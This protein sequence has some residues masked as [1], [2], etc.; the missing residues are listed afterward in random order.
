MK[1]RDSSDIGTVY[2]D[3]TAMSARKCSG[4]A[5][6]VVGAPIV[7]PLLNS[8]HPEAKTVYFDV[9]D[10]PFPSDM[11]STVIARP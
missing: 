2:G 3:S 5:K 8:N 4:V 6:F 7:L 1:A 10:L 11:L 9:C